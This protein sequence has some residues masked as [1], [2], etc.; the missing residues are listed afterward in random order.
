M[1]FALKCMDRLKER[2]EEGERE[3]QILFKKAN[4]I[5]VDAQ[6]KVL[7][8]PSFA[9]GDL[10]F[11]ANDKREMHRYIKNIFTICNFRDIICTVL[12]LG[13]ELERIIRKDSTEYAFSCAGIVLLSIRVDLMEFMFR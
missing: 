8:F 12:K 3:V 11:Q 1:G 9:E 5:D 4:S 7:S 6:C 2:G 10:V 13:F